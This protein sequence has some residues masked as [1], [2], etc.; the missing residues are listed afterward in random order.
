MIIT[1]IIEYMSTLPM[2][3]LVIIVLIA[4]F[5]VDV[6]YTLWFKFVNDNKKYKAGLAS[7]AIYLCSITGILSILEL[8][9]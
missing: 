1:Q 6:F 2:W 5:C 9:N 8:N 7:C 3:V 4:I